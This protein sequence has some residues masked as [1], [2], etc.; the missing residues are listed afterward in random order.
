MDHGSF[1]KQLCYSY[2]FSLESFRLFWIRFNKGCP[3]S[4]KETWDLITDIVKDNKWSRTSALK[5]ELRLIKLGD[6]SMEAYFWKIESLVTILTSLDSP[7]NDEDVVHYALEG[8]PDKYDQVFRI[9]HHK[10]T[11][12]DLKTARSTLITE[13]MC[14]KSKSLVLPVDSSSPMVLMSESGVCRFGDS[15]RY[16]HDAS[17][18]SGTNNNVSNARSRGA[19]DNE[20][21]ANELLAKLLTQL[22]TLGVNNT[23]TPTHVAFL[24]GPTLYAGPTVGP[25]SGPAYPPGFLQPA[26]LNCYTSATVRPNSPIPPV[27]FMLQA[28]STQKGHLAQSTSTP[29][30]NT[31]T[32]T[33]GPTPPSGQATIL[34]HAFTTETLL[35][36]AS[37]A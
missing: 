24:V 28:Q 19:N 29:Q 21:T 27:Y 4:A 12:P 14:L 7:V 22:G 23:V 25:P 33:M 9:M 37:G 5:A 17:A 26:N 15:C 20:P 6:L 2:K 11:F 1:F 31:Q 35:D 8:L 16:V 36:N 32:V 30:P 3:K 10:D 34:P 18:R 13:E